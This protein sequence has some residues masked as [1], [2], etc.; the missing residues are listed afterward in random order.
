MPNADDP[1][2]SGGRTARPGSGES[3]QRVVSDATKCAKPANT[4]QAPR[5]RTATESIPA[6]EWYVSIL[7]SI[8]RGLESCADADIEVEPLPDIDT[9]EDYRRFLAGRD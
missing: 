8:Q 2:K 3:H 7:A 9:H 6:A 1:P 5:A 4:L